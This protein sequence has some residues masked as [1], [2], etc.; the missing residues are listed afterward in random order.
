MLL[1]QETE[2]R[3]E[4]SLQSYDAHYGGIVSQNTTTCF[5]A[6]AGPEGIGS[7]CFSSQ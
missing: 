2:S 7:R 1:N 6:A 4:G 3:T 5:K